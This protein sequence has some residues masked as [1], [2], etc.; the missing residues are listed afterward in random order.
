MPARRQSTTIVTTVDA[1]SPSNPPS[2]VD[3]LLP[4]IPSTIVGIAG[5]WIVH[6]LSSRRQKR[7]ELFKA[8]QSSR[9][10]IGAIATVA[11]EI[12]NLKGGADRQSQASVL[13]HRIGRLGRVLNTLARRER[14]LEVTSELMRFRRAATAD[15]ETGAKLLPARRAE[16]LDSASEL[17]GALDAGFLEIY[18]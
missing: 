1:C 8:C 16:I 14:R 9:E 10:E 4:A 3:K 5:F 18:G 15:I 11:N 13:V 12:W 2:L 17:E 6:H 7:D